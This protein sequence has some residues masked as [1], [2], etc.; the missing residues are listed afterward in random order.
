[1][2]CNL[3]SWGRETYTHW[4]Q[5]VYPWVSPAEQ[6]PSLERL[7]QCSLFDSAYTKC[8]RCKA[9]TQH[10]VRHVPI[11]YGNLL[12]VRVVTPRERDKTNSFY[13]PPRFRD[14]ALGHYWNLVGFL[15]WHPT[16]ERGH[17]T[18]IV[19]DDGKLVELDGGVPLRR[20]V[21]SLSAPPV[22]ILYEREEE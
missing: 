14:K 7:L 12:V 10:I 22:L 18:T 4:R 20:K 13:V 17:Y 6:A 2:Q 16:R 9:R 3:Q 15:C 8:R 5:S 1:M 11:V 21:G 19:M